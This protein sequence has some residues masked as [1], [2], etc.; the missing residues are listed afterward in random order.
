L[1]AIYS[2][3]REAAVQMDRLNRGM[4]S[5]RPSKGVSP[6][7]VMGKDVANI[8]VDADYLEWNLGFLVTFEPKD[9]FEIK[10]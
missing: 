3:V 6:H 9:T 4:L 2:P 5:I 8:E 7:M 1:A 10:V